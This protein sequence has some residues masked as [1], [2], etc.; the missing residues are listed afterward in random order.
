VSGDRVQLLQ[1]LLNLIL[2]SAEAM[3]AVAETARELVIQ[4]SAQGSNEVLV[5]VRDR[6]VG[7]DPTNR[8]RIFAP[9]FTTKPNGMGMGLSISKSIIEAHGGKLWATPNVDGGATFHFTLPAG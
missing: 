9:F 8:D 1:V 7:L 5:Q 2:N 4:S 3:S 6:G